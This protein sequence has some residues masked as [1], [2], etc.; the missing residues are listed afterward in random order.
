MKDGWLCDSILKTAANPSPMSTTP[1]FSPGPW[2]TRGPL[3]GS[4]ACL[5]RDPIR[6]HVGGG[7]QR[8]SAAIA[9]GLGLV[10]G[11]ALTNFVRRENPFT[12]SRWSLALRV[13]ALVVGA[14][15][16]TGALT[17]FVLFADPE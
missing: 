16:I 14:G 8:W 6:I 4:R 12:S 7:R 5:I 13:V 11:S 2:M 9:T 3:V 10:I 1:A 17:S 15:A